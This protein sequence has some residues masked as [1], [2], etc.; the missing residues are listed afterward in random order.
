MYIDIREKRKEKCIRKSGFVCTLYAFI[1]VCQGHVHIRIHI[2]V[3]VL[4]LS[5][6]ACASRYIH[7][8][9]NYLYLPKGR[10]S[11]FFK[12]SPKPYYITY[13]GYQVA[14]M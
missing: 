11:P 13:T 7:A 5:A 3:R 4:V 6:C 9:P 12:V 1:Y 14:N 10:E 2:H 8:S